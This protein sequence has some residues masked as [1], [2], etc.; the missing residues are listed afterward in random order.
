VAGATLDAEGAGEELAVTGTTTGPML[1]VGIV[2]LLAGSALMGAG[3]AGRTGLRGRRVAAGRTGRLLG[4]LV[5]LGGL[6]VAVLGSPPT[7]DASATRPPLA[8]AGSEGPCPSADGV[9]VVVDFGPLGGGV[10]VRC[11]PGA[12]ASGFDA[13][14]RAGIAYDTAL[15]SSG[16]LCRIAG[17]PVADPCID[18]SPASAHW[19]Y[20]LAERGGAWCYSNLGAGNRRPPQGTVEGWAFVQ[21]SGAADAR[22]P[23]TAP[24]AAVKGAGG[25]A[26]TDCDRTASAPTAPPVTA[27]P[28]VP[29][30]AAPPVGQPPAGAGAL[31]SGPATTLPYGGRTDGNPSP[32]SG[33]SAASTPS[34]PTDAPD[35]TTSVPG[36]TLAPP[37]TDD[38]ALTGSAAATTDDLEAGAGAAAD[39]ASSVDLSD[40]GRS[41]GTGPFGTAVAVGGAAALLAGAVV[42]RRRRDRPQEDPIDLDPAHPGP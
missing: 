15:R 37:V 41:G 42:L 20:W 40:S 38:P 2:L 8:T 31:P 13:L 21:G 6:G 32:G 24:P 11:A 36:D 9:T 16:F 1:V 12:P 22:P 3:R 33:G 27:P 30:A 34:T 25:L 14:G 19:S 10:H 17:E 18:P 28:V 29:A 7:A 35:A 39:Q 5:L 23:A 4:A 26:G